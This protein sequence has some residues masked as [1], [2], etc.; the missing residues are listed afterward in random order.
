MWRYRLATTLGLLLGFSPILC[1]AQSSGDGALVFQKNCAVCHRANGAGTAGLAP[2]INTNPSR[3]AQVSAGRQQLIWT[4]LYGM[5]GDVTIDA[6]HYN[7][8]MPNF[9]NTL[10]DSEIALVLNHV[11]DQLNHNNEF[12]PFTAT[13]V[14]AER[15]LQLDGA[16]VL[17]HRAT[18][19]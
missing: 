18:L 14:T 3:F 5:Y 15:N 13:E 2:P 17:K 9:A 7:F 12:T 19:P 11:L 1:H 4:V 6:K 10:S 16:A 8:K